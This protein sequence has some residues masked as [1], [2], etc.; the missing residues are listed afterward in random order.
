MTHQL[1]LSSANYSVVTDTGKAYFTT[2]QWLI[3]SR[4]TGWETDPDGVWTLTLALPDNHTGHV[5]WRPAGSAA[6][7]IPPAWG[8]TRRRTL[9]GLIGVQSSSAITIGPEPVMLDNRPVVPGEITTASVTGRNNTAIDSGDLSPTTLD[10]T[11]F[12]PAMSNNPSDIR[13]QVFTLTN[14]DTAPL[15]L[16][17]TPR[18]QISGTHSA[19]FTLVGTD[20]PNS[21][22]AG[23]SA[24]F[25]LS[26]APTAEGARTAT[27]TIPGAAYTFALAG[28]GTAPG[29]LADIDS[30]PLALDV[31]AGTSAVT[32]LLPVANLGAANLTWAASL[33]A[34][35]T[36]ADSNAADGPVASWIDLVTSA[37][38][39]KVAFSGPPN[40]NDQ[41]TSAIN[42]GFNFPFMGANRTQICISTN[43]FLTFNTTATNPAPT[44][45]ALPTT[46][47]ALSADTLCVLW[48]DLYLSNRIGQVYYQLTAPD[49]FVVSWDSIG[50]A[51]DTSARLS[52]QVVLKRDGTITY[53]YN[54]HNAST[55]ASV[56]GIQGANGIV[57]QALSYA[58]TTTLSTPLAVRF[59]PPP[60]ALDGNTNLSPGAPASWASLTTASGTLAAGAAS[61]VNLS[62]NPSN[63]VTG[64]TYRTVVTFD[65]NDANA[66]SIMVPLSLTVISSQTF[67]TWHLAS[68]GRPRDSTTSD[69]AMAD[70]DGDGLPNLLEY[71]LG[72]N[73]TT[74]DALTYQP[75]CAITNE[76][77]QL[78]F[79][80]IADTSLIYSVEA[81]DNLA[82]WT[83][84]WSTTGVANVAGGVTATDPVTTSSKPRRFLKL[85]VTSP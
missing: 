20:L 72:A 28:A 65:T 25:I 23:Q 70:T 63:L 30:T 21:I 16:T 19:D 38:A 71:A 56:I 9:S 50:Y 2:M 83:S 48:N 8:V 11:D 64:Q 5:L 84:V 75:S 17:G 35:Y 74:T 61:L 58:T 55:V 77:L 69:S 27:V 24:S 32:A 40:R 78:S 59:T 44:P 80:R 85:R 62:I 1:A 36:V 10:G 29:P 12:G 14:Y 82:D 54:N 15:A 41:I 31:V 43:G 53:Q 6:F 68:L 4:I 13:T 79:T 26:F 47:A 66:P 52:F 67:A 42:I 49:T 39:T 51:N 37:G 46:S 81:S 76:H 18:V 73:P 33:P 34:R 7:S 3:G 60:R 45:A 57:D 22:A